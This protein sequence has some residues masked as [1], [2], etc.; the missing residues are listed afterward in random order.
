MNRGSWSSWVAASPLELY[1]GE[2][3]DPLD[4]NGH[5]IPPGKR[6]VICP[7]CHG[8]GTIPDTSYTGQAWCWKCPDG[9]GWWFEDEP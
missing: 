9:D 6:V 7:E 5:P 1:P 3:D 4:P 2:P 8:A